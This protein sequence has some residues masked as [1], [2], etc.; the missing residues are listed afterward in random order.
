MV[1]DPARRYQSHALAATTALVEW[2]VARGAA[3]V[4]VHSRTAAEP[5]YPRLGFSTG[6]P[7]ATRRRTPVTGSPA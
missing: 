6:S 4:D 5:L 7:F 3:V 2:L 1:A